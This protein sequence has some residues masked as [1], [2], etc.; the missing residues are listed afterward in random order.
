MKRIFLWGGVCALL[1]F[2]SPFI[3]GPYTVRALLECL[4][5]GWWHFLQ[6]NVPRISGNWTLF[7]SGLVCS[8]FLLFFGQS[9]LRGLYRQ[10]RQLRPTGE[11]PQRWPSKWTLG[12]YLCVWLLFVITFGV[13]GLFRQITWLS[14]GAEP[15]YQERYGGYRELKV[16]D[17]SVQEL[18]LD[19]DGEPN[20]TLNSLC[21][22]RLFTSSRPLLTEDFNV[23]LFASQAN[24]VEAYVIVRRASAR[25]FLL[26]LS[27]NH[28]E[29]RPLQQLRS[30]LAEL[31]AEYRACQR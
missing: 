29:L 30:T 9:L 7:A 6:R 27:P 26:R 28:Y 18:L 4:P 5:L 31:E 20:A 23:V 11:L 24:R 15:W 1:L 16:A 2:L 10:F 22:T 3:L 14:Q 17:E 12:L 25:Q 8:G 19:T 13:G 21:S